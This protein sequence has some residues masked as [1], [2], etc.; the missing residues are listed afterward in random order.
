MHVAL[1]MARNANE[2]DFRF[3]PQK[4]VFSIFGV[5]ISRFFVQQLPKREIGNWEKH[6]K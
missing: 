5:P 3:V 4:S 1:G 2:A 6:P